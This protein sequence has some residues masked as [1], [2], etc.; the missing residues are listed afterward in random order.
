ML[1]IKCVYFSFRICKTLL[2]LCYASSIDF[3]NCNSKNYSSAFTFCFYLSS[4]TNPFL[5]EHYD[6][7]DE[8][9]RSLYRYLTCLSSILF[10]FGVKMVE[11]PQWHVIVLI[12]WMVVLTSDHRH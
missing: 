7:R 8:T 11:F 2:K 6:C 10:D 12:P 5:T 9:A 3:L 1:L 4:L